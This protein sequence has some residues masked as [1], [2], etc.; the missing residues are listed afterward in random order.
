MWEAAA[1]VNLAGNE[2]KQWRKH[3][4]PREKERN[5]KSELKKKNKLR[6]V[7]NKRNSRSSPHPS[8]AIL[9]VSGFRG[10][11]REWENMRKWNQ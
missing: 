10:T 2:E 8:P 1:A 3:K 11:H 5:E 4:N 9:N 6:K 7:R